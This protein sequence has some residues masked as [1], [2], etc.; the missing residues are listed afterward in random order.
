MKHLF[1]FLVLILLLIFI[2]LI[3]QKK[4]NVIINNKKLTCYVHYSKC[5]IMLRKCDD[6]KKEYSCM[7]NVTVLR[8]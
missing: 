2:S 6:E 5:G 1:A 3:S 7:T 8:D 4:R